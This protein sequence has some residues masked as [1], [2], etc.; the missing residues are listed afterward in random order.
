MMPLVDMGSHM[1]FSHSLSPGKEQHPTPSKLGQIQ[2]FNCS[3]PRPL[4]AT[5]VHR[6]VIIV[7]YLFK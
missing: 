3:D 1:F 7:D 5:R 6:V 4:I 2:G